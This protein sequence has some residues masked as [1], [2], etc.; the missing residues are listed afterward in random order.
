MWG[1]C[2]RGVQSTYSEE[3]HTIEIELTEIN[4]SKMCNVNLEKKWSSRDKRF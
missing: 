1:P 2:P 4:V 3:C